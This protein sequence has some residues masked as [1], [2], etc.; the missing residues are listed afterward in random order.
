MSTRLVFK[1]HIR[2]MFSANR[3]VILRKI[4]SNVCKKDGVDINL[5]LH[6]NHQPDTQH[7]LQHLC[8]RSECLCVLL[9]V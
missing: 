4:S 2:G 5:V 7:V 6:N 8:E 1:R 3:G 9:P